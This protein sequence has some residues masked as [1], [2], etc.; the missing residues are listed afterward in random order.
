MCRIL[1]RYSE[2]EAFERH[3]EGMLAETVPE[4]IDRLVTT[5]ELCRRDGRNSQAVMAAREALALLSGS[6]ASRQ[7]ARAHHV[8]VE[9]GD[10]SGAPAAELESHLTRLLQ[11]YSTDQ[12]EL[13]PVVELWLGRLQLREELPGLAIGHLER[14]LA[15]YVEQGNRSW[16][17]YLHEV[18]STVPGRPVADRIRDLATV[19]RR[20]GEPLQ[21]LVGNLLDPDYG[22]LLL[23]ELETRRAELATAGI[24]LP[25]V[26]TSD[27]ASLPPQRCRICLWGEE[28]DHGEFDIP[29]W[30]ARWTRPAAARTVV[31]AVVQVATAHRDQL[32]AAP[33]PQ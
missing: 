13:I 5:A 12:P 21:V 2:A 23:T 6:S 30:L 26:Q 24:T 15:G 27:D 20:C 10:E 17:A 32:A 4:R 8:I 14:S 29:G 1:G 33:T 22:G 9:I 7:E 18:I 28:V 25:S 31:G 16:A 3:L 19:A 11:L